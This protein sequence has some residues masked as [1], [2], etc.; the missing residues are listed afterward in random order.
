MSSPPSPYLGNPLAIVHVPKELQ[1]SLSQSQK[2]KIA[3]EFNLSE[4][5][6]LH[7]GDPDGPIKIDIFMVGQELPFAGHPTVGSGWY[8]LS[9][10][11]SKET[12]IL[13]TKAGDIPVI[14]G[15]TG[16]VQLQVPT[17]FKIHAPIA[18]P[19]VK[20]FQPRL[21]AKDYT[22]G[23]E[24]PE[25]LASI[26]KGMTFLLVEL[27]SEDALARLQ[28]SPERISVTEIGDWGSFDV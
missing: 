25:P 10:H 1:E 22:N 24:G 23:L 9:T 28:A 6:F 13:R 26:V 8:L 18:H 2:L 11:P 17:N 12:I 3:N 7:E 19:R 20:I 21:V 14:R 16:K 5:V 15:D 4:T 27:T